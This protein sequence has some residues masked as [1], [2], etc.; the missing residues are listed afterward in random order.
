MI[1]LLA[2]KED[3]GRST[4]ISVSVSSSEVGIAADIYRRIT[5]I[6]W[7]DWNW[8]E[9]VVPKFSLKRIVRSPSRKTKLNHIYILVL[10]AYQTIHAE[11]GWEAL[12]L[13]IFKKNLAAR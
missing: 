8:L 3:E 9:V 2:C 7:D 5:N 6:S 13:A 10:C 4:S 11:T 12:C 1:S